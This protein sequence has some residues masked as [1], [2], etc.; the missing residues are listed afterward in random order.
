MTTMKAPPASQP[1]K[2]VVRATARAL[3]AAS[4]TAGSLRPSSSGGNS[5]LR[6]ATESG[7]PC[8]RE[9]SISRSSS[10]E[11]EPPSEQDAVAD[12]TFF[13]LVVDFCA[14]K[15]ESLCHTVI[16]SAENGTDGSYLRKRGGIVPRQR[17]WRLGPMAPG[18]VGASLSFCDA[19][20]SLCHVQL[21]KS[22]SLRYYPALPCGA[23]VGAGDRYRRRMNGRQRRS[24]RFYGRRTPAREVLVTTDCESRYNW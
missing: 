18:D 11:D 16:S 12:G 7:R 10:Y 22:R 17:G 6:T 5:G 1:M 23:A 20:H 9:R 15:A 4:S 24:L 13:A 2:S 21:V 3:C 8:R 14:T 19:R